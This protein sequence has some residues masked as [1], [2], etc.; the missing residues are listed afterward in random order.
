MANFLLEIY[1]GIPDSGG[2]WYLYK[3][4]REPSE[5]FPLSLILGQLLSFDRYV[6]SGNH[7]SRIYLQICF[8]SLS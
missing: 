5:L 3:L 1:G 4:L 6:Y 8:R 2:A 7:F